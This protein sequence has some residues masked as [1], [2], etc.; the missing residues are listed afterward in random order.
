MIPVPASGGGD[1][2]YQEY[3]WTGDACTPIILI[4]DQVAYADTSTSSLITVA[5]GALMYFDSIPDCANFDD[6]LVASEHSVW[7]FVSCGVVLRLLTK[8]LPH[9]DPLYIIVQKNLHPSNY[10]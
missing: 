2:T 6:L 1:I 5:N 3:E 4:T 10:Q 8:E 7:I 9:Y